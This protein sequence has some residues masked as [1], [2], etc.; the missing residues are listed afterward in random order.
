MPD[1]MEPLRE[2]LANGGSLRDLEKISGVPHSTTG[3]WIQ[4]G[5]PK[6]VVAWLKA[7]EALKKAKTKKREP[8]NA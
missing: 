8:R 1:E 4:D 2:Y 7:Q 3:R 6:S 5:L